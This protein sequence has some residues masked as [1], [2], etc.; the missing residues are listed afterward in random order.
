M[1]G[2]LSKFGLVCAA[3]VLVI[4]AI[5]GPMMLRGWWK[6]RTLNHAFSDYSQA[7]RVKDYRAAYAF[8][9]ADFVKAA[10]Y[11]E[12]VKQL[13]GIETR[14]GDLKVV[15]QGKTK[16][17]GEGENPNWVGW[18]Y[19][20]HGYSRGKTDLVYEFHWENDRWRLFGFRELDAR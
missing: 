15:T 6:L 20:V 3:I 2:A 4:F 18:I 5:T 19:A 11:E 13:Q 8:G 14:L 7:L 12:F 9:S 10:S 17:E 16:V 1:K